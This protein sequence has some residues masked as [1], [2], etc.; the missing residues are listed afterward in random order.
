MASKAFLYLA[1]ISLIGCSMIIGGC[2]SDQSSA[3]ASAAN[4]S[5]AAPAAAPPA[6]PPASSTAAAVP[7]ISGSPPTTVVAGSNY[8]FV[9][10][11]TAPPGGAPSFAIK[12]QPSWASFNSSTGQLSGTAS[13]ANV[14]TTPQIQISVSAAG[15]SAALAPFSITVNAPAAATTAPPPVTAANSTDS[16]LAFSMPS[17]DALFGSAKKVFAHYFRPFPL[18]INNVA[19]AQDYYNTQYL[20]PHGESNKWVAQGGFL[21]QR[22]LGLPVSS[23]SNWELMNMEHEVRLAIARGITGFTFDVLSTS[24][25]A[26]N[27]LL[28]TLLQAAEAVDPRF[29]I[30]VMPD[31][32]SLGTNATTVTQVIASVAKSP[33]A[34]KLADGRL[35]VTAFDASLASPTWWSSVFSALSAQGIEVAF[36]PTFLGWTQHA[37]AFSSISYGFSDWGTAT[38]AAT[39][40]IQADPATAHNQYGKIYMTPIDSQQFRPKDFQYWEAG[41]SASFR[42]AWTSSIQGGAD[43]VQIVTW[44]DYSESGQVEP[45]T[46]ATLNRTIGTGFYDLNGYYAA[47]FLTGKQPAITHDVLYYFYRREPSSAAAP[48]QGQLDSIISSTAQDDIEVVAFLTAPGVVKITIGGQSYS[49]DAPA[50]VST[51]KIPTQPGIPTFTLSRNEAEVFSFPGGV[52]IYGHSGI[53]SGVLD[54]TYWSGSASQAGVC[55]L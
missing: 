3:V 17:T 24:D 44:S 1:S 6:A 31:L 36:V 39:K 11:V 23:A 48:A 29:K 4:P 55:S 37:A 41:N 7:T 42:N 2:G 40:S 46:D 27:G 33:A 12:N 30:V 14:G 9:P 26:P 28:P 43:W 49:Q 54:L 51:F 53:P 20:S 18:Q 52:Q 34:Y 22:P 21:R 32:T 25:T 13:T 16:C 38:A 10:T 35:V 50:G 45:S 5:A 8:T 19:A 15:A 47:W